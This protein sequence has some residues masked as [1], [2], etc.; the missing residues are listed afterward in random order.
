VEVVADLSL[1]AEAGQFAGVDGTLQRACQHEGETA[2]LEAADEVAGY[3]TYFKETIDLGWFAFIGRPLLW[4]LLKFHA[5]TLNWGLAIVLLT[6]LV[7]GLTI[8]FTTKSMRSMKAMAVLAPEMKALQEKYK[9]DRQR[10]QMETMALYKQ[11]GANPFTSCLPLLLQTPI[12]LALYRMLSSTGELYQQPFIPGWIDDLTAADPYY[13][14]PIILVVTMFVQA[15]LQPM[16]PVTDSSQ[17]MQQNL[18]KYGLPLMF[19]VMSFFFPA[20]LTLYIF[21]N[22]VLSALHSIYMNK[23]DKKSLALSA[24]IEAAKKKADEEKNK[25]A[26]AKA[27]DANAG[28][29]DDDDDASDDAPQARAKP[30]GNKPRPGGQNRPTGGKKKKRR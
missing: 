6:M 14:L 24:K 12:W 2:A 26:A 15:R 20:G 25:S 21:T 1:I 9:D 30:A 7:K 4:L 5:L 18:M 23:F 17:K 28:D 29:D 3:P 11:H 8:P 22:T 13:V 27:K 16:G 10:L 19:G